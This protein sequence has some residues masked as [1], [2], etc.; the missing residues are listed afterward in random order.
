MSF[1]PV[2]TDQAPAA[3]GPYAQG[4]VCQGFFFSSGQIGLPKEGGAL[5]GE[6]VLEQAHQV[7]ANIQAVLT[8]AECTLKDV[9]KVTLFLVDMDDFKQV[10]EHYAAFFDGHRPARSTVAVQALPL[11]ARIEMEVVARVSQE[12]HR[13]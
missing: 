13:S 11:G 12:G 2:V 8:A 6:G 3:I 5:V 7:F 9:V 1:F 4:V 10:N